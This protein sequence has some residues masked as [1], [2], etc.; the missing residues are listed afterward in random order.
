MEEGGGARGEGSAVQCCRPL[1]CSCR[2]SE[3]GS[4]RQQH[5]ATPHPV[6]CSEHLPPL[7]RHPLNTTTPI[8]SSCACAIDRAAACSM[9][10]A[11]PTSR[12][13]RGL[14]SSRLA[15]ANP[16]APHPCRGGGSIPSFA[17][18]SSSNSARAPQRSPSSHPFPPP[19]AM[20]HA[21]ALPPAG[22]DGSQH[23]IIMNSQ[24]H[25]AANACHAPPSL[26]L[27]SLSFPF[28]PPFTSAVQSTACCRRRARARSARC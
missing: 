12:P 17:P 8:S 21:S 9:R 22:K 23:T 1:H 16:R 28:L 10:P 27:L 13:A 20:T 11:W 6:T 4:R 15:L 14:R 3:S 5:T 2:P 24:P 25:T 18:Y 19:P 7:A 26:P